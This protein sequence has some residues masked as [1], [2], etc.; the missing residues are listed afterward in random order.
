[1]K[2]YC[3][4]SKFSWTTLWACA[5]HKKK[6]HLDH[7]SRAIQHGIHDIFPPDNN[8]DEDP[9]SYKKLKKGDGAW[10]ICKDVLGWTLDGKLKTVKL[11]K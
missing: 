2:N 7:V 6:I 5:F 9:T 8:N 11:E 3:T 4:S 10:A 1:M